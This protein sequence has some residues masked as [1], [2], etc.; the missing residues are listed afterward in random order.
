MAI[1]HQGFQTTLY[2]MFIT[3]GKHDANV[4]ADKI[5]VSRSTF[6]NYIEGITYC[7]VDLV[8]K[9]YNITGDIDFLTFIIKETD[10]RLVDREASAG[11]KFVLEETLDVAA[12]AGD[13]VHKVKRAL[14]DGE[15]TSL[16]KKQILKAANKAHKEL[17][18]LVGCVKKK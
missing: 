10:K 16:E 14:E 6:Y 17:E 13:V 1:S 18:E 9:I 11:E 2:Y 12:A 3:S 8:A 4:V 15:M 5:G 7:P